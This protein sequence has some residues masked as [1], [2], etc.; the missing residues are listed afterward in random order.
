MIDFF[1]LW[2]TVGDNDKQQVDM[3][4]DVSGKSIF[5]YVSFMRCTMYEGLL[6]FG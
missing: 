1:V 6:L 3:T 2:L 4:F 5:N